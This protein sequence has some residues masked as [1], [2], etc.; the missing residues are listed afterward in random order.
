VACFR[1]GGPLAAAL[2]QAAQ[3]MAREFRV[4]S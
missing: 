4:Q 1:F 3:T 2:P